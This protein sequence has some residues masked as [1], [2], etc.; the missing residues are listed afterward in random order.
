MRKNERTSREG[1]VAVD[2]GA[3][4]TTCARWSQHSRTRRKRRGE[5]TVTGLGGSAGGEGDKGEDGR[6]HL[7]W[8]EGV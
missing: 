2:D 7:E 5:R 1:T 8:V 3:G 6:V 4:E